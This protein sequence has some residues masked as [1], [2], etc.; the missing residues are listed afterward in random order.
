V[1]I[2][3][4]IIG[5]VLHIGLDD[6]DSLKGGCTTYIAALLV[7]KLTDLGLAFTDYPNLIR[8]NPNIPWKT[9]GNGAVSL[10]VKGG[11]SLLEKAREIVVATVEEHADMGYAGTDPGIVFHQSVITEP[12][13]A[14]A[15]R[16]VRDVV[17]LKEALKLVKSH[18]AEAMGYRGGRGIIGALAAVGET[19]T[20]DHTFELIAYRLAENRG[21]QRRVDI[22][23]VYLMDRETYPWTFNNVDRETGRVLVTPRGLDPVLYG[24]RGETPEAVYKAHGMVKVDEPIERWVVFRTNHGTD[25]HL[26]AAETIAEAKPYRPIVTRGVVSRT[27]YRIP[28]GHVVFTLKDGTGEIDCAAYEPT[29]GFRDIVEELVVGDM[30]EVYGGVRPRGKTHP[31]T[32]NLEKI[33]VVKLAHKL[34]LE[35]PRCPSCGHRMKSMGKAKGFR[36]EQC[37]RRERS[38]VKVSAEIPRGLKEGLYI[39]P[40]RAHR[41]LTKPLVRYGREK[42]SPSFTFIQKW[43]SP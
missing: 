20:M 4:E 15:Q 25:A 16:A 6:T 21:S 27:P 7:E 40:L 9:R 36:C 13:K 2:S 11:L 5:D 3:L 8:L 24:I 10:R 14:F 41:H 1:C 32:I 23:S 26:G 31:R 17:P 34:V 19:L 29:G 39:T 38:V 18:G 42:F 12:L 43:H 35:N 22:T 28:G 37:G 33:R 30:V